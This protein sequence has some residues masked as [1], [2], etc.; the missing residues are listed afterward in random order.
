VKASSRVLRLLDL[1]ADRFKVGDRLGIVAMARRGDF[2]P[3]DP[4]FLIRQWVAHARENSD[5]EC[6]ASHSG[7]MLEVWSTRHD[8]GGFNTIYTT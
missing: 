3:G 2:G 1:P 8:D 4:D 6:D 5:N 7:K